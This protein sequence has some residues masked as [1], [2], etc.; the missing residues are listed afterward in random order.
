MPIHSTN[1]TLTITVRDQNTN[2]TT[3]YTRE[4]IPINA[5]QIPNNLLD[6][7][8]ELLHTLII[9]LNS[10][11]HRVCKI[12]A[13]ILDET[14]ILKEELFFIVPRQG[15]ILSNFATNTGKWVL[16]NS[17]GV[18]NISFKCR[19]PIPEVDTLKLDYEG[20]TNQ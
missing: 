16:V 3:T 15:T 19:Q 10:V 20:L 8:I 14:F 17:A 13:I 6:I 1:L 12:P 2:S 7:L 4:G 9:C 18:E 11:T 5:A